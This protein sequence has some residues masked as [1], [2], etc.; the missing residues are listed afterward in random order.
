M[1]DVAAMAVDR[2]SISVDTIVTVRADPGII[3]CG[4]LGSC[5]ICQSALRGPESGMMCMCRF[6]CSLWPSK[7]PPKS[8]ELHSLPRYRSMIFVFP[9]FTA[10]SSVSFGAVLR[11]LPASSFG[12]AYEK[13]GG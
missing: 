1:V 13:T 4:L 11:L 5:C 8:G 12:V 7:I 2:R 3:R 9:G 6:W 10:K